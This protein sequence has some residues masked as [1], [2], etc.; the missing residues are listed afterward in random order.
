MSL[1]DNV[2]VPEGE[3]GDWE[4]TRF[5]LTADYLMFQN[6]RALRDGYG[7]CEP[8]AYTKLTCKGRGVV[9]SDT[10]A[11]RDGHKRAVWAAKGHVLLNGLGLG[12]VLGAILRLPQVER[13]TVVELEQ[14]VIDLVGPHYACD[15]LEI[16]KA[17]AFDY[18]PPKAIR[19]GAVWHDI[20]D[21]ISADNLPDMTRLK[22]KYGRRAD[23]QEC[24]GE[25]L[26]RK[27]ARE[28]RAYSRIRHWRA[29]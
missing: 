10:T 24:W 23:W 11:E 7:Y 17:S 12:M 3:R 13:V 21:G 14:D 2:T 26:S 5:T 19:Y 16:V 20:W 28:E 29:A 4:I 22:R 1:I 6:L 25:R 27:Q 9:M 15:R 8:G 18:Q